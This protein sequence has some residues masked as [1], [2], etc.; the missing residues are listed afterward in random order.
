MLIA[1]VS[2]TGAFGVRRCWELQIGGAES[3]SGR[4]AEATVTLGTKR[5]RSN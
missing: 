2:Y 1:L 5:L 3:L 4:F